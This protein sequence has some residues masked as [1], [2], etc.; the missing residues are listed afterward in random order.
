MFFGPS[1]YDITYMSS[2]FEPPF[3]SSTL[4]DEK[5]LQHPYFCSF[6]YTIVFSIVNQLNGLK[7]CVWNLQIVYHIL[8]ELMNRI[9]F[10]ISISFMYFLWF[11]WKCSISAWSRL[12]NLY[13]ITYYAKW[14]N[15]YSS[16]YFLKC[17]IDA[18]Y[19]ISI[20]NNLIRMSPTSVPDQLF[21]TRRA[22]LIP[23]NY[24]CNLPNSKSK[25]C[26]PSIYR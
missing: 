18:K 23:H 2:F 8:Y 20:N 21:V 5:Y 25:L 12:I 7:I 26:Y 9:F 13:N 10:I 22:L 24:V 19:E 15:P 16:K 3:D 11:L 4:N 1:M 14:W 17:H 6:S